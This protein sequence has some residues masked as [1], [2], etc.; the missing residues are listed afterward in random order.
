MKKPHLLKGR[1]YVSS[2]Y[3]CGNMY[4]HYVSGDWDCLISQTLINLCLQNYTDELLLFFTKWYGL[5][6]LFFLLD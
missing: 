2:G 4:F 3:M 5:R 1:G 6:T